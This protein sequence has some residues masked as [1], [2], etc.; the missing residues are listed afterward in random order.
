MIS[1]RARKAHNPALLSGAPKDDETRSPCNGPSP[2][3]TSAGPDC[4][5]WRSSRS[6]IQNWFG[7]A[8]DPTGWGHETRIRFPVRRRHLPPQD[9]ACTRKNKRVRGFQSGHR[10]C[11]SLRWPPRAGLSAHRCQ[12]SPQSPVSACRARMVSARPSK[13][14]VTQIFAARI[15]ESPCH[16]FNQSPPEAQPGRG[17][18]NARINLQFIENTRCLT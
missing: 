1:R 7:S 17:R 8:A 6:N 12:I 11:E 4:S 10:A 3:T 13:R 15:F 18:I 14:Q 2:D 9:K 16:S 5:D